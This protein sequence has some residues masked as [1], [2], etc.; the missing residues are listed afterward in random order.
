VTV[1]ESLELAPKDMEALGK[2]LRK[3]CGAG[4][5]V[6]GDAIEVQGDQRDRIADELRARG[7]K[8]KLVGG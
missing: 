7:F 8:V 2:A 1:I 3:L 5:T 6:K 4:G